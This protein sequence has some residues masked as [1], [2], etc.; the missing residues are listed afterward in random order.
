VA[1]EANREQGA[2]ATVQRKKRREAERDRGRGHTGT[3][4]MARRNTVEYR[5]THW[6]VEAGKGCLDMEKMR[7]V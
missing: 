2:A 7:P 1:A 5:G 6:E 3:T 4:P